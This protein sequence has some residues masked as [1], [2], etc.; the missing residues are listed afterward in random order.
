MN[1]NHAHIDQIPFTTLLRQNMRKLSMFIM[2]G[3][4]LV[5]F[6]VLT[7][8]TNLTPRNITNI[9]I[10]NSYIL[11]L[12]VGMVLVI[13]IG[14]IDL[15]V[16]SVVAFSGAISAMMYNSGMPFVPMLIF[17]LCIGAVIGAFQGF[18]IAYMRIPAF[19]VT[20]SGM[21]L[22]RG[23]TY[24]ITNVTPIAMRDDNFKK[25]AS[26]SLNIPGFE[27]AGLDG[28]SVVA[29]ILI[30][31]LM[32]FFTLH[33]RRTRISNGFS[34]L[35][36]KYTVLRIVALST[37]I[38]FVF[39]KF[40]NY[41]GIPTVG[42][43]LAVVTALFMFITNNTVIGRYIYAVGG[44][45]KS[46][47]LSG[48]NSENVVFTTHLIMGIIC[49]LSGIVFTAYMNSALPQAGDKFEMDAIASCFIGGAAASGGIGT[50]LGAIIGGLVIGVINNGM[51]LMNIRVDWQYVVK[52]LILLFAVFYDIW[53][54][55]KSGLG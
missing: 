43:V 15:S 41:R 50:I 26:G 11:I 2:L 8:G 27:I 13:I 28:L 49:G 34:V 24:I 12:A 23:L 30:I 51:S 44:N 17:S 45:A 55:R 19:I 16:G 42:M 14:N 38:L 37:L 5:V 48:I 29:A 53:N 10:Q 6:A 25:I 4:I 46:A 35:E 32:A 33:Q 52:A 20:L 21:L 1:N 18:W 39:W 40:A 22:F 54:R 47:K 7:N 9:F 31:V 36:F 3:L